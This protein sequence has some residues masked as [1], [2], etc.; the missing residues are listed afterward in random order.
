LPDDLLQLVA[1]I[2]PNAGEAAALTGVQVQDRASAHQA[3]Q[4][5]L[6]RGVGAVAVQ[7]GDEGNLLVWHNGEHFLPK[8]SVA[9][10]DATGAG[11]A[12]A[13]ALAVALAE[14]RSLA[15][16]GAFAN[17]AAALKTT[18]LGAQAALPRRAAVLALLAETSLAA[19]ERFTRRKLRE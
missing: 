10:I 6:G 19:T 11:D 16:A 14:G 4:Q 15:E 9:S 18:G 13:A 3:A 8:L 2:K 12:F 17:A 1:V 7:A 5:L